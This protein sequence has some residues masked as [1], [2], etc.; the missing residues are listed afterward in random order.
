MK[1]GLHHVYT[2][3]VHD[4]EGGT[5]FYSGC[6]KPPIVRDWHAVMD[7]QLDAQG[8]VSALRHARSGALREQDRARGVG[9]R[10]PVR[11]AA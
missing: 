6:A 8:C 7:E 11:I 2:G 10:L 9:R 1:N 5:T 4:T 3:N